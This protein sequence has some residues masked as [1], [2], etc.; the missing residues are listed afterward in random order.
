MM[1]QVMTMTPAAGSGV[2]GQPPSMAMQSPMAAQP[3]MMPQQA[4]ASLP[5]GQYPGPPA[6]HPGQY[7][8]PP[9]AY[10]QG[11][12]GPLAFLERM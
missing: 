3:P 5:Q 6:G 1:Q 4:G 10:P 7:I 8:M 11:P 12:Q 9:P 2:A